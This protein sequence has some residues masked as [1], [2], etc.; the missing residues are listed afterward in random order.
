MFRKIAVITSM[1]LVAVASL[2]AGSVQLQVGGTN[3]LTSAYAGGTGANGCVSANG[4]DYLG[5]PN[6]SQPNLNGAS[7]NPAER[8]YENNLFS[9]VSSATN[10]G[11]PTHTTLSGGGLT[12]SMLNDSASPNTNYWALIGATGI[13]IPM[14]VF[15]VTDVATMLNDNWGCTAGQSSGPCVGASNT[16]TQ[17]KF[18]FDAASNGSDAASLE[19]VTFDLVNGNE[20][21]DAVICN[22]GGCSTDGYATTLNA[23][24]SL[25]P[26]LQTGPI[27]VGNIT[28]NTGTLYQSAYNYT[29]SLAGNYNNS[30]GSVVLDYQDFI[31]G[32]LF[33]NDYLVKVNISNPN[34]ATGVSRTDLSAIT[35][36]FNSPEPST[37][38]LVAGGIGLIGFKRFRRA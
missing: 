31:F 15:G 19:Q 32:S 7:P 33:A 11:Y 8:N 14:G 6:T 3:G 12:F 17:V 22:T 16:D 35:V 20:I 5:C 23:A 1:S 27:A 9:G 24:N 4:P 29:G 38:L 18:T 37:W 25:A 34:A 36:D 10:P 2:S 21:R 28:I 26:A 30:S 13:T